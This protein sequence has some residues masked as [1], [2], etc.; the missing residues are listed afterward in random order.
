[1]PADETELALLKQ[2]IGYLVNGFDEFR[3]EIKEWKKSMSNEF[4]PRGE[5]EVIFKGINHEIK[6][7]KEDKKTNKT[8]IVSWVGVGIAG[9]SVITTIIALTNHI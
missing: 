1:M 9:I 5:L 2:Q 6:E 4:V 7:L 3:N 8:L